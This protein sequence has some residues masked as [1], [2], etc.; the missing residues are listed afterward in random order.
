MI[1]LRHRTSLALVCLLTLP[2]NAANDEARGK[3]LLAHAAESGNLWAANSGSFRLRSRV[4]FHTSRGQLEG[5]YT[6]N[7]VSPKRSRAEWEVSGYSSV[8]VQIDQKLWMK[9]APGFV[10][11]RVWQA[12]DGMMFWKLL[13]LDPK[14]HIRKIRIRSLNGLRAECV[15]IGVDALENNEACFDTVTGDLIQLKRFENRFEFSDYA[16]FGVKRYPRTI[17]V[18][19]AGKPAAE[20]RVEELEVVNTPSPELFRAPTGAEE[21]PACDDADKLTPTKPTEQGPP[22]YPMHLRTARVTGKVTLYAVVWTDGSVRSLAVT[23]SVHPSLDEAAMDA[24]RRWR[25]RPAT[26]GDIPVPMETQVN[27]TFALQ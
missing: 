16:V 8:Q 27:I 24:V 6:S 25:Y 7:W 12:Q 17:K 2:V 13:K 15:E 9:R 18:E 22:D 4:L 19:E 20:V 14:R 26:C 23:R 3:Q 11:L 1:P 5:T 21:W 10:P